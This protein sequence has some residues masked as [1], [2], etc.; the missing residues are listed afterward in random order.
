MGLP[1]RIESGAARPP[2]PPPAAPPRP[3]WPRCSVEEVILE[4]AEWSP[5]P[6]PYIG[7]S[8]DFTQPSHH[9]HIRGRAEWWGHLSSAQWPV[10]WCDGGSPALSSRVSTVKH[11]TSER[12][13]RT[14]VTPV[15]Q[16]DEEYK[17]ISWTRKKY[18]LV[19][20]NSLVRLVSVMMSAC[21]AQLSKWQPSPGSSRLPHP[22]STLA[23]IH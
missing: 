22:Y 15:L 8:R 13:H 19:F 11:G 23:T 3:A 21:C 7:W 6:A 4:R 14:T 9:P 16:W 12:W 1:Q 18:L 2:L 17:N 20:I 5:A 10:S